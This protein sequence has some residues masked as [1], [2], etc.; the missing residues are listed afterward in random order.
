MIWKAGPRTSNLVDP[1]QFLKADNIRYSTRKLSRELKKADIVLVD[2]ASTPLIE[3]IRAGKKVVCV[4]P[5]WDRKKIRKEYRKF[6]IIR[7][8]E[9]KYML[10]AIKRFLITC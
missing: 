3:G 7:S 4:T 9:V 10:P 6:I 2:Y 1:I 5:E 8:H